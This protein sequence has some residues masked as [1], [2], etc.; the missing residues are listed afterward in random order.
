MHFRALLNLPIICLGS[1]WEGA[2]IPEGV[3]HP[4]AGVTD[5]AD[6]QWGQFAPANFRGR[7]VRHSHEAFSTSL[8]H[9]PHAVR[10]QL[11]ELG[12]LPKTSQSK[13]N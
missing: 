5:Q 7:G 10:T 11:K 12:N 4:S 2:S 6:E 1:A 8:P 13:T 9:S 3:P